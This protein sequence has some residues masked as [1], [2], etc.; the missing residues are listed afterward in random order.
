[1]AQAR[2]AVLGGDLARPGIS[3]GACVVRAD[4]AF[5]QSPD[6]PGP[7]KTTAGFRLAGFLPLA[8]ANRGRRDRYARS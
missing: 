6:D 7:V 3:A 8:Y 2:Q 4:P 5:Y 1:M